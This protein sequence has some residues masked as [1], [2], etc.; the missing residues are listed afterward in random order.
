MF[1]YYVQHFTAVEL[2][3]TYYRMPAERTM[4]ALARKAPAGFLFWVKANRETTHKQDR[5]V[6]AEFLA[7]IQPMADAG[8]LA[9]VLLQFPQSFHRTVANRKYLA[10]ALDDL[11]GPPLAVEFRHRS[12]DDPAAFAGLR[13]REVT[14]AVPDCPTI[15]ELFR[16]APTLTTS[17]GYFRLHS[18]NAEKWY[19][20]EAARYD[21]NYSDDELRGIAKGWLDLE[22]RMD[23]LYGFFNNCHHAQ[24]A[25]N[26]AS[27]Q[28]VLDK[29][30]G[31]PGGES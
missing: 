17:T 28:K 26:A 3:F 20:G 5:S 27:F 12:W 15:T 1:D 29:L 10:A 14:L 25:Q 13:E 18:R 22:A 7:G 16:V 9:G 21:Y 23:R 11:S 4:E 24:A 2:N 31:A 8:K 30:A 19:A 6:A